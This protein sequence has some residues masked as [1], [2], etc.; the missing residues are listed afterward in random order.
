MADL[1]KAIVEGVF[2]IFIIAIFAI[3]VFPAIGEATGQ[4]VII[5]I[6]AL[7]LL[8]AS[9]VIGLILAILRRF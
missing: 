9:L 8:G 5:Y 2:A 3:Y 4:N 6:I 7:A 1:I